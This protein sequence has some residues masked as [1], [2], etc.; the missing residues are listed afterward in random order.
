MGSMRGLTGFA[1]SRVNR[2]TVERMVGARICRT[3]DCL[4]SSVSVEKRS[5]SCAAGER[6]ERSE[7]RISTY[8]VIV[9]GVLVLICVVRY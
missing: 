9:S 7:E 3:R 2:E 5:S 4:G 1:W 8:G 6:M